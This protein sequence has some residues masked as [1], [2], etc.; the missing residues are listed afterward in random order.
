MISFDL[1]PSEVSVQ[2][3]MRATPQEIRQIVKQQQGKLSLC[4]DQASRRYKVSKLLL[5][6][7][8]KQE[9][10][11]IGQVK[12]HANGSIDYGPFQINEKYW[13]KTV[14]QQ[15][16]KLTWVD[17]AFDA[18]TNTFIATAILRSEIDKA[19]GDVWQ[20]VGNYHHAKSSNLVRHYQY[21]AGVIQHY[22]EF[23]QH[24]IDGVFNG[25]S[26]RR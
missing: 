14:T 1:P 13:L 9:G 4:I 5:K 26:I 8:L 11:E 15:Y 23:M 16:P 6:A 18:C 17:I 2:T 20:G 10:G 21:T 7:L 12:R 22:V 3:I 19:Q 25:S 24:K